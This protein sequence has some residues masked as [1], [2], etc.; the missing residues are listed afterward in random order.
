MTMPPGM[1]FPGA[2]M[3]PGAAPAGPPQAAG[4]INF[5]MVIPPDMDWEPF[6]TTDTLEKDGF[7]C[8]KIIKESARGGDKPGVWF[9][10]EV[11]DE[12]AR[13]KVLNRFMSDSRTTQKDTWFTWRGLL[14]S[15]TG[16]LDAARQGLTYQPGMFVGQYVYVKTGAYQDRESGGLRTG[17]DAWSTKSEWETAIKEGKHRW[18]PKPRGGSTTGAA[19]AGMLPGGMPG[20]FPTPTGLP[21]A[22]IGGGL[23]GAP[24]APG[25]APSTPQPTASPMQTAPAQVAA[26]ASMAPPPPPAPQAPQAPAAFSFGAPPPSAPP[27]QTPAPAPT[28][29]FGQPFTFQQPPNGTVPQPTAAGLVASFPG[30]QPPQ[31]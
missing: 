10:F 14:R 30:G 27:P 7:Y 12:D 1:P 9:T 26:P 21:G 4:P 18:T 19:P 2:G 29:G 15:L 16:N 25:V 3:M 8:V 11:F 31:Q 28:P 22:P 20:G 5:T 17:I 6:E 13:G 24:M 23:P